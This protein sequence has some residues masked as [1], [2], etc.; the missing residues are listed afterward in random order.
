[1]QD[2]ISPFVSSVFLHR[3]LLPG[4][5]HRN[6]LRVTLQYFSKHF[7]D[8]EFDSLTVDGL[9]NE[10]LSVIQHEVFIL[11][12]GI[13]ESYYCYFQV[14]PILYKLHDFSAFFSFFKVGA[15]S[16]ISVLQSWK[17]FCTCYFNNWC[18]TNVAC[19]LL[20]DSA[21]QAVGVI[22]KNSVSMCRSLE[23]IELLVFGASSICILLF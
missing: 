17:T 22:R 23:D 10:I 7:T 13:G 15:D 12:C 2:Q 6:V 20:I 4:V 1:M 8:S 14:S 19:G 16:P 9:R 18:K 21:T 11:S 5:Y 3:L